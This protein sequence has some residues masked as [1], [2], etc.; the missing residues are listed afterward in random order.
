M[1]K[2][3]IPMMGILF[4]TLNT[5]AC[6]QQ[7]EPDVKIKSPQISAA[8]ATV[9][10]PK[11]IALT[12]DD[13][14][15]AQA[16]PRLLDVLKEHHA[17]ATFFVM[18]TRIADNA[19]ILRRMLAEGHT[20]GNHALSHGRLTTMAADS[21]RSEIEGANKLLQQA[22]GKAPAVFRPPYGVVDEKVVNILRA[23]NLANV[24]WSIYPD[25]SSFMATAT[26][27]SERII[28]QARDGDIVF[29][30]D[31]AMRSVDAT[32]LVIQ[33]LTQK[34]FVFVTTEELLARQGKIVAGETYPTR[35][36]SP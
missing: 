33:N 3:A 10:E 1:K 32:A 11:Y 24:L 21:A 30:H 36:A 14:P 17:K 6:S 35:R 5:I 15:D 2:Y 25:D 28:G 8:P 20:I 16:T 22:T 4:F 27:I 31:T 19:P 9:S 18:G 34:G 13:G 12:F 23:N 7:A 29:L 26:S